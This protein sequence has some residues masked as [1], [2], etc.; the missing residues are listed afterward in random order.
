LDCDD[1]A[2]EEAKELLQRILKRNFYRK[3]IEINV[4]K[5]SRLRDKS[6][7]EILSEIL[8]FVG[9]SGPNSSIKAEEMLQAPLKKDE[10]VVLRRKI[11]KGMGELN[12]VRK[13]RLNHFYL[14]HFNV[15]D[16]E[17]SVNIINR[18]MVWPSISY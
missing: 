17:V 10:V 16:N 9:Q 6:E 7:A 13:V 11:D 4:K 8:T 15:A 1:P 2:V 18:A 12:P 5:E 3:V 14:T